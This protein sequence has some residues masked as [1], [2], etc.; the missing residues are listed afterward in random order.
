M[1]TFFRRYF[2]KSSFQKKLHSILGFYPKDTALYK[3]ALTH[4]SLNRGKA[5]DNERLEFLGDAILGASVADVLFDHF[6]L[7]KEGFLTQMRSKL[8]S[9]KTLNKLAFQIKLDKLVRRQPSE[10]SPSIY[11]NALEALVAAIYIDKGYD[12][13]VFFIKEKLIKPHISLDSLV[14]EV[15]SY[16][17]KCLE[18]GQ[19]NKK[20]TKFVIVKSEGKD[21]DKKYTIDFYVDAEKISTASGTSIKRAEESAAQ[22]AYTELILA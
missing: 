19:Q 20:V 2:Y 6:E 12:A 9:R 5:T 8:V 21:H 7:G 10:T 3:I 16:K 15:A 4:K 18:W 1:I 22:K 13:S 11:G 14:G 17:S